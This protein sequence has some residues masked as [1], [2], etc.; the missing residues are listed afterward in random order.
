MMLS[1]FGKKCRISSGRSIQVRPSSGESLYPNTNSFFDRMLRENFV[2][3][4]GS[5]FIGNVAQNGGFEHVDTG[6]NPMGE[7]LVRS[8]FLDKAHD[9]IISIELDD[10]ALAHVFAVVE[11]DSRHP[12]LHEMELAEPLEVTLAKVIA[13]PNQKRPVK[14]PG[15]LLYALPQCP[16]AYPQLNSLCCAPQLAV[17]E[18]THYFVSEV[19]DVDN[20]L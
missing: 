6:I 5:P 9:A 12:A 1:A 16:T 14:E 20:D 3:E 4:V 10:S 18:V 8:R 2:S 13:V 17:A 15:G 11:A 19:A 7:D